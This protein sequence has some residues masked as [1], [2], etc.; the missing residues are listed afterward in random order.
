M[1]WWTPFDTF[2]W[3]FAIVTII[4]GFIAIRLFK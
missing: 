4:A 1:D 3:T 2:L